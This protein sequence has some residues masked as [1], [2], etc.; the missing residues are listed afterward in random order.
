[1]DKL[2]VALVLAGALGL[3][4][5]ARAATATFDDLPS[6]PAV[7]GATGLFFANDSSSTYAGVVWDTRFRVVGDAYRVDTVTPGPRF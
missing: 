3:A 7:D 2:A 4:A 5:P 1:M 6:A